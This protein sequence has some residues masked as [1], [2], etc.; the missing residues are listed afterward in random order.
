MLFKYKL[1]II[2]ADFPNL[3]GDELQG[4]EIAKSIPWNYL[5]SYNRYV[6]EI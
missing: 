5:D 6:L 3:L 2:K 4:T 1:S